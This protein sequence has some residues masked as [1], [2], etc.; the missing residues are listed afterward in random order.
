MPNVSIPSSSGH[1]LLQAQGFAVEATEPSFNPLFVGASVVTATRRRKRKRVGS[2]SIPSSSGHL[3][4]QIPPV[5]PEGNRKVSIPSSSGHLLLPE[6]CKQNA[7][8][9]QFQS[10]LSRARH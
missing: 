1:L 7:E 8:E 5:F 2:V 9:D 3:L 4:L 6:L 10:P